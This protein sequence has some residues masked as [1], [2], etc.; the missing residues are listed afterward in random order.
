[1]PSVILELSFYILLFRIQFTIL[2]T[3]VYGNFYRLAGLN[4]QKVD[5]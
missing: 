4:L 3:G 5:N 1:M 2:L